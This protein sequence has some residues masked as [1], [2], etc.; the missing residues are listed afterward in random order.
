MQRYFAEEAKKLTQCEHEIE[1]R[2]RLITTVRLL[3][4]Q[5]DYGLAEWISAQNPLPEEQPQQKYLQPLL[6]P[7]DGT[8]VEA[9]EALLIAAEQIGWSGCSRVLFKT[10]DRRACQRICGDGSNTTIGLLR[11]LVALRNDGAEGHGLMGGYDREAEVDALSFLCSTLI[12]VLPKLK[13]DSEVAL[14]MG[15]A[16]SVIELQFLK[17]WSGSPALIRRVASIASDRVR[18]YCQSYGDTGRS[19]FKYDA[20]NPFYRLQGNGLPAPILWTN[21]WSPICYLPERTTDSFA[22]RAQEILDLTDWLNDEDSRACLIFGDGGLGK[23]TLAIELLHKVLDEEVECECKPQVVIFHTAKRTQGGLN[24]LR[25]IGVGQ[26]HLLEMLAFVHMIL[27][28]RYPEKDFYALDVS[29]AASRLQ[30]RIK[31]ELGLSRKEVLLI[32]D[33]TETLIESDEERSQLGKEITEVGRRVGRLLLTSR[34]RELLEA[35]P[36]SIDV[37]SE[38][39]ALLFLRDRA[40]KLSI[41]VISRATEPDL[42]MSIKALERRPIVLEA[43]VNAAADPAVR[44]LSQAR[45]KVAAMLQKDLGEFLFSDAWGRLSQEQR[46]LLLLMT[47]VGDAHD[48]QSLRICSAI[49]G[50]PAQAAEDAL[51][52]SGGIASK[53]NVQGQL[54]ITF[55]RNFIEYAKTR[56]VPLQ[57]KLVS[58]SESE[59]EAAR[60]QYSSFVRQA[61]KFSGDRVPEA[62]RTPEARA[63][64]RARQE[65]R[66]SDARRLYES[67]VLTDSTNG[68]LRDRFAYFL[69]HDER[70]ND[71]ALHQAKKAVELLPDEGEVWFTRGLL[72]AR[73][74]AV[75]ASEISLSKAVQLGVDQTRCEVQQTWAYL[76]TRPAQIALAEK[77]L[78]KLETYSSTKSADPRLKHEIGLLRSRFNYLT[79]RRGK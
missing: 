57:G 49:I 70:D 30:T 39:D 63:A 9:L 66:I 47:R 54:Q 68:W 55:S 19:E 58:P 4:Q 16:G 15:P 65:G 32:I 17:M 8:L 33:N 45:D 43:F 59:V 69:F 71:A 62:F 26:P 61:Q 50:I 37:L 36:V 77:Q 28:S 38:E 44:K 31:N 1:C 5:I 46:R 52:E 2:I 34:R 40:S 73:L 79:N 20:V 29:Q 78:R 67:A 24:G 21:S 72:E 60:N 10:V 27:F 74:G 3:L 23:T 14:L 51:E 13:H 25:P 75:R 48:S 12:P 18:V 22:G 41:R 53:V 56:T 7:T 6:A 76:K 42:R 11:A 64:H 35:T